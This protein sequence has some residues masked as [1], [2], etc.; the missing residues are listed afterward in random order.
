MM[1]F[2][3][4]FDFKKLFSGGHHITIRIHICIEL[5][6][7]DVVAVYNITTLALHTERLYKT[8]Q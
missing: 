4:I 6:L 2:V 7:A 8:A 3:F 5:I 1:A